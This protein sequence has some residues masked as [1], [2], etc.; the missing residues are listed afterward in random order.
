MID[1]STG[2][3][4][5]KASMFHSLKKKKVDQLALQ[6]IICSGVAYPQYIIGNA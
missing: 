4:H 3:F 6:S 2:V 5:T 1:R